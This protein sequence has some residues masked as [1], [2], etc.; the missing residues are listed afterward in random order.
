MDQSSNR[1]SRHRRAD[2]RK[3]Q[4][5]QNLEW[6]STADLI[7]NPRNPRAHGRGQIR[8]LARSIEAFGFNAPILVDRNQQI[9]AGHGRHEAAKLLGL[10]LVPVIRLEHLSEAQ[11]RAYL[12]ADNKLGDRSNWDD[13][14]L[15]VE[16]KE[17]SALALDFEIEATGFELPEID[18]HIQSLEAPDAGDQ[19]DEFETAAGPAI[20]RA[21]DLWRLGEHAI[22][23]GSALDAAAYEVLLD[24]SRAAGAFT[25][26][27]YNLKIDGYVIG[28]GTTRH[29]EFAMAAGEMTQAEFT[30]FL[31]RSLGLMVS[32]S[33]EGAILYACMDWRHLGEILAAGQS[34]GCELLNV[35]VWVKS[36]GGMGALYRSRHEL[37]LVFRNGN[38]AHLNNVQLGRYGRYRTNVWHYPG[39]NAFRRKGQENGLQYH[40]TVKPINMVADALLDTTHR[41]DLVLDPFLGSGTTLLAAER[42][43]R[44]CRGI[45]IDPIYVDTAIQRWERMTGAKARNAEGLAFGEI[46]DMRGGPA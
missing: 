18:F 6:V 1:T 7:A 21:G 11:A 42:T 43:G 45:E 12:L 26:P 34:A 3:I 8:A 39:A 32:H 33:V 25:D 28:K 35:C 9:V 41:G 23:C 36:N 16:L 29:R 31:G 37:V 13:A 20:S 24:G 27:P 4:G 38:S 10:Q 44:R 2:L 17:L 22:Y 46:R 19:A 15:A 14:K 5:S 40:P 30:D